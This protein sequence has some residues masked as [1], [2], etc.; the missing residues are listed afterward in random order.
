MASE[1]ANN[2]PSAAEL[3]EDDSIESEGDFIG[4]LDGDRQVK[5]AWRKKALLSCGTPLLH[6]LPSLVLTTLGNRWRRHSRF[7]DP[8]DPGKTYGIH[9]RRRGA[10]GAKGAWRPRQE[11]TSPL[12]KL[13]AMAMSNSSDPCQRNQQHERNKNYADPDRCS[14]D[15]CSSRRYLP[16]HYFDIIGGSSTGG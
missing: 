12:L 14:I 15:D 11:E 13:H 7:L 9:C 4:S 6:P 3:E 5:E 8:Q 1:P 2:R 16:C 10:R